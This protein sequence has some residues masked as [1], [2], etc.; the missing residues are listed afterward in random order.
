MTNLVAFASN[1]CF[2]CSLSLRFLRLWEDD[3]REEVDEPVVVVVLVVVVVV[4][5]VVVVVEL[6][7]FVVC[8]SSNCGPPTTQANWTQSWGC[9]PAFSAREF[10]S[11]VLT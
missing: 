11:T 1:F 10:G 6:S 4:V 9:M 7:L 2:S 5:P 8:K 3:T